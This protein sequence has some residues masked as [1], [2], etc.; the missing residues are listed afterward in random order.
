MGTRSYHR[1]AAPPIDSPRS[2][3]AVPDD[4]CVTEQ[5]R[6]TVQVHECWLAGTRTLD[7]CDHEDDDA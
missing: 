4:A 5:R 1:S 3:R 2:L 6:R 7:D